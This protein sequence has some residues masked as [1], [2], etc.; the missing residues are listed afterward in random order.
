MI[1][2]KLGMILNL[3]SLQNGVKKVKNVIIPRLFLFGHIIGISETELA[4]HSLSLFIEG[5]E[6]S[7]SVAA[8]TLYELAR[9]PEWQ[10][11]IYDE[12]VSVSDRH[13]NKFTYE[14]LQEMNLVECAVHGNI[15]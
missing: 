10:E 15:E 7:S 11:R 2:E 6:T 9:N 12:V 1:S 5:F 3:S 14:A 8:F 13:E 4:G